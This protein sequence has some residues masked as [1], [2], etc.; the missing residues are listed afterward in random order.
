MGLHTMNTR[1]SERLFCS[2]RLNRTTA[3]WAHGA[4]DIPPVVALHLPFFPLPRV[5]AIGVPETRENQVDT[6]MAV[7][8]PPLWAS[9]FTSNTRLCRQGLLFTCFLLPK[10]VVGNW[11]I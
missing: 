5:C 3:T 1:P 10:K 2:G 11:V 6:S 8:V 7:V 4:M 9:H